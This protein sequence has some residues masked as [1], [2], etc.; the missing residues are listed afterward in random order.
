MAPGMGTE[1]E[2]MEPDSWTPP[3][4]GSENQKPGSNSNRV[5]LPG[6]THPQ[7]LKQGPRAP[8]LRWRIQWASFGL[9]ERPLTLSRVVPPTDVGVEPELHS[10]AGTSRNMT[11]PSQ[12]R[13]LRGHWIRV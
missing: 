5:A 13:A 8:S 3:R 2:K 10:T 12:Q 4:P 1:D 9:K 6:P 7:R 11:G